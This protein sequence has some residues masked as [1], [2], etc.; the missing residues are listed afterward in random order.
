MPTSLPRR[1]FV[2]CMI[3]FG[4]ACNPAGAGNA[5]KLPAF[6]GPPAKSKFLAAGE[7]CPRA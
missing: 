6:K 1:S 5:V 7:T 4:L 3:A 2:L